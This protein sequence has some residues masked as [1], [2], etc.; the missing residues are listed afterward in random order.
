[1]LVENLGGGVDAGA[2]AQVVLVEGA[3]AE[4]G[5][6]AVNGERAGVGHALDIAHAR[7]LEAVVH[8]E[9]IQP[10]GVVRVL[11]VRDAVRPH[12]EQVGEVEDA[13]RLALD[14][15]ANHVI[16]ERDV[17]AEELQLVADSGDR[18]RVG[19]DVHAGDLVA[20]L[21]ETSH[22]ARAR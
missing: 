14:H 12:A 7:R 15:G 8:A 11:G 21:E 13:V 6:T 9:D 5:L 1:M 3:V 18:G 19:V 22:D 17:A 2:H 4:E 16:H 20:A 10:H